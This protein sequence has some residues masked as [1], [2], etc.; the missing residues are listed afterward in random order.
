M[1]WSSDDPMPDSRPEDAPFYA[2]MGKWSRAQ[3]CTPGP[4]VVAH[5]SAALETYARLHVLLIPTFIE[6]I[7]NVREP[8]CY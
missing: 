6:K 5:G 4:A 2:K 7:P 1:I 8:S 3:A